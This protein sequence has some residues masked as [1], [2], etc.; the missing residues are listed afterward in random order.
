MCVQFPLRVKRLPAH[1]AFGVWRPVVVFVRH[2]RLVLV[3]AAPSVAPGETLRLFQP[4]DDEAVSGQR[5]VRGVAEAALLT[6]V[7]RSVRLVLGKVLVEGAD[8]LAGE[9]ANGALVNFENVDFELLQRL[10]AR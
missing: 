9:A 6:L 7:R 1:F 4:M 2:V 3:A 8:V 10:R 5:G